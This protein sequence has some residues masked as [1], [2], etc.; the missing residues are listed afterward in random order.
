M[1]SPIVYVV[2]DDDE[3]RTAIARLLLSS[4]IEAIPYASPRAFLDAIDPAVPAC[5]VLDLA[6]PD[7]DGLAVQQL[8]AEQGPLLSIV[9]LTAHGDLATGVR[10]MKRGAV[11]FLAKPVDDEVLLAAVSQALAR[12]RSMFDAD[13]DGRR[14]RARLGVLTPREREVLDGV[15]AGKLNKQIAF[16]L[17]TSEKTVKFHRSNLMRKLGLRSVAALVQFAERL[18]LGPRQRN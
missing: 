3:V 18:G 6:M 4:G 8:L 15:L 7:L 16:D 17:G 5:V 13:A 11:D 9:F 1:T 14:D 2:D 10:A 12:S